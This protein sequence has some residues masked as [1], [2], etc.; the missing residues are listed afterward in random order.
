MPSFELSQKIHGNRTLGQARKDQSDAIIES[1]WDGDIASRVAWIYDMYHDP[2]PRKLRGLDPEHDHG[3]IP[4]DIKF[5]K[6]TSQTLNKDMISYHLMM[7]MQ[8]R[9]QFV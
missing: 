4:L 3:K 6:H 9:I 1:T 2:D 7:E 5:V 8:Y